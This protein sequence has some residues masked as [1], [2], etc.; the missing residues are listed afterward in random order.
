MS[1]DAIV[2]RAL[3][4]NGLAAGRDFEAFRKHMYPLDA[5]FHAR[6]YCFGFT[7]AQGFHEPQSGCAIH[8]M[9][10]LADE[11][12]DGLF[13]YHGQERDWLRLPEAQKIGQAIALLETLASARGLLRRPDKRRPS[14]PPGTIAFVGGDD[15]LPLDKRTRGGPGHVLIFTGEDGTTSEGGQIDDQNRGYL[16]AIKEKKRE[17]Y[18]RRPGSWWVRDAGSTLQG[19]LLGWYFQAGDLPCLQG[20][21]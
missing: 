10:C 6:Q 20:A 4:A 1:A 11:E 5:V 19:R 8:A 18:E 13:R 3:S 17:V 14:L 12:V 7:D 9:R 21:R 2:R 15:G 16:T